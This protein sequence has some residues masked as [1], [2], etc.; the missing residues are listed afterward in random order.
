LAFEEDLGYDPS[1]PAP[2]RFTLSAADIVAKTFSL[3]FRKFIQ[4]IM[5]VG[6]ISAASVAVSFFL[7]FGF[8][9]SVGTITA[10]PFSYVIEV[11]F[12]SFTNPTRLALII[13]FSLF[14]FVLNAIIFG[15]AI[16]FTLDEYGGQGGDI[17]QSFS[18][19]LSRFVN[20]IIVQLILGLLVAVVIT[21]A[22]IFLT[23]ALGM[24]DITDPFD[25]IIPPG[26]IE[27]MLMGM[28]ILLVG[29]IILLYLQVRLAPTLAIVIDT[30]MSAIESFGRAWELTSGHFFHVFGSYFLLSIF[31]SLA[32]LAVGAVVA[33]IMV[34]EVYFAVIEAIVVALLFSAFT[35]IYSVVLYRD[36]SS[37]TDTSTLQD[38]MI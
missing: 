11:L 38:L 34:P 17:G 19:S 33:L 31:V 21:P 9:G 32:G 30:E 6:I 12:Y 18:H 1:Q 7:L 28:A 36:L 27:Q 16:K 4:Y 14:A 13:G 15:A 3:W 20:V 22:M 25:P 8:F 2:Q 37:R 35:Y 23:R 29:G 26:A 10:N 24:I 5:I